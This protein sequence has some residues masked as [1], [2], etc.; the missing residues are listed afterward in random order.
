MKCIVTSDIHLGISRN[1]TIWLN[2]AQSFFDFVITECHSRNVD[3][4]CILGDF[5]HDRK[6][7]YLA[8]LDVAL[9]ISNR[10]RQ[11]NINVKYI[12][13][14]H[15]MFYKSDMSVSPLYI[16]SEFE[17]IQII[18]EPT[19]ID[20]IGFVSW[21]ND[22]NIDAEYLFGHLEIN[23]FPMANNRLFYGSSVFTYNISDFQRYKRVITGHFHTPSTRENITYLGSPYHLTFNDVDSDRGIYYFDSDDDTFEFIKYNQS[24]KFVYVSSED[25][26]IEDNIRNNIV[27]LIFEKDYGTSENNKKVELL[28]QYSPLRLFTDFS[29]LTTE[30]TTHGTKNDE[31]YKIKSNKEILMDFI[32]VSDHPSHIKVDKMKKILSYMM[33]E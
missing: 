6:N 22:I 25:E 4:L 15:D 18:K 29:K 2:Q 1:D 7:L 13:G 33:D 23:S 16:F 9:D 20:N 10:L 14:N 19:I 24:V 11:N 12:I 26:V 27:K 8:T 21:T 31:T 30:I 32:D 28:Q 5:F 17:N 3:T